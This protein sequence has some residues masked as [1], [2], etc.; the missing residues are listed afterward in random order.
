MQL[1]NIPAGYGGF[2]ENT[3]G[4]DEFVSSRRHCV[5]CNSVVCRNAHGSVTHTE[6]SSICPLP[7]TQAH[8]H[9]RLAVVALNDKVEG[10]YYIPHGFSFLPLGS[11]FFI[12]FMRKC[13]KELKN[14]YLIQILL[15][16]PV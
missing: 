14:S 8:R 13:F 4:F 3:T 10:E 12:V 11:P 16:C 6:E 9:S 5:L 1:Q 2:G 15:Y 7:H